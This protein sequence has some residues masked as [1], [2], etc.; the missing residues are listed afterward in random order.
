MS[1]SWRDDP[2]TRGVLLFAGTVVAGVVAL[3]LGWRSVARIVF[4]PAQVPP[5]VS[6]GIAGLALVLIGLVLLRVQV[7]RRLAAG[8]RACT[9][10][11]LVEADALLTALESLE[12]DR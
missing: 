1:T 10:A 12:E 9:E 4:V 7:E 11:L 6:G 2:A 8:E 3:V 5:F